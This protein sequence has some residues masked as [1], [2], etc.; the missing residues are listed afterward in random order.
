MRSVRATFQARFIT[1]GSPMMQ[2]MLVLTAFI[3]VAPS[4][5]DTIHAALSKVIAASRADE[6]C[7]DY[8][9]Y[10]DTQRP[11]RYVFVERWRDQA[12]LDRH[13]QTPHMADWMTVAAPRMTSALGYLYTV[14][15]STELRPT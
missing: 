7:E 10:E 5:R 11:G 3:E 12:A 13:L 14:S 1:V 6:G 8:G 2:A 15:S 9:C 4:D